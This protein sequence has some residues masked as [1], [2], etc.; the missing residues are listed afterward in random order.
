MG[1]F[2]GLKRKAEKA[3][4]KV[5]DPFGIIKPAADSIS[6]KTQAK[7][8]KKGGARL[9]QAAL[10]ASG[11]RSDA[12]RDAGNTI[13]RG[14]S[15]GAG[16][17]SAGL[18]RS[19]DIASNELLRGGNI[20]EARGREGLGI[21][22]DRLSPFADAFGAEDIARL[23]GL[24][25][26][27]NAQSD[28]ITNNPFFEALRNKAKED[29]FRTQSGSGALGSSGTDEQL[30]NSFLAQGQG[31]LDSQINRGLGLM[32]RSQNAATTLGTGSA[33]ILT[34]IGSAQ[35]QAIADAGRIRGG[36]M[37][38]AADIRGNALTN[39]LTAQAQGAQGAAFQTAGGLEDSA[40]S[41]TS[42]QIAAANARAA[43]I[44]NIIGL[45]TTALGA[46]SGNP[47][48]LFQGMGGQQNPGGMS[49]SAV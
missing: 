6:G 22:T 17:R 43:G 11:I 2:S 24:S 21:L 19:G 38:G 48:A 31:L 12:T 23:K 45:G 29:T 37:S 5:V 10:E 32:D 44:N 16:I 41:L 47:F 40:Q 20:A 27:V 7:A 9:S 4:G 15:G 36:A 3:V 49:G 18:L 30:Q 28:F 13:A 46:M 33:N 42:G 35:N 39:A 8:A 25:T 1:L 26:D 34:G 14:I